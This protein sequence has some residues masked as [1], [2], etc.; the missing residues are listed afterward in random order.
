MRHRQSTGL[1]RPR[2]AASQPLQLLDARELC[3]PNE[4]EGRCCL[5][6]GAVEQVLNGQRK[7]VEIIRQ[8]LEMSEAPVKLDNTLQG[9]KTYEA[10]DI[11]H[12]KNAVYWR[13]VWNQDLHD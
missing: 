6:L 12:L 5:V 3:G 11:A 2:R 10:V 7:D 4:S 13:I 1:Y 9:W 8:S